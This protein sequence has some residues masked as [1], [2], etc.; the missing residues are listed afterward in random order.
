MGEPEGAGKAGAEAD[1]W[2]RGGWKKGKRWFN[3]KIQKLGFSELQKSL[4][5]YCSKIKLPRAQ[6][7]NKKRI[8]HKNSNETAVFK[9]FKNFMARAKHHK[10]EKKYFKF[11]I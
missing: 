3:F 9:I 10:I 2:A 8:A 1:G 6:C 4:N 11:T 7:N 5:F